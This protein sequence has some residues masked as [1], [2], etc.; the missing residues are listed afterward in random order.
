MI[1]T[2]FLLIALASMPLL[3]FAQATPAERSAANAAMTQTLNEH[4]DIERDISYAQNDN[5]RQRLDVY[6][7]KQR[8]AA[9][10]PVIVFFHGGGWLQGDKADCARMIS[11]VLRSGHFAAVAVGY[12][13]TNEATWP[14]QIH[15]S[16]AGVRWVRANAAK[17]GFDAN[18][19]GVWGASAGGHLALM[20]GVTGDVTTLE[21]SVGS[22]PKVSSRVT[23]VANFLGITDLRTLNGQTGSAA[24]GRA[25]ELLIGGPV[26]DNA[27]KAAA[28]SPIA[29]VNAKS[30][31]VLT[32]HGT[33]DSTVPFDQAV[34]FDAALRKAGGT[35][36]LVTVEGGGHGD[37][38]FA[39]NDRLDAFFEKYLRNQPVEIDTTAITNWRR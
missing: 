11:Q 4:F 29:Y 28:A 8:S 21:G 1:R 14:A 39:A 25:E 19:I 13:L 17:Y 24:G 23:A 9:P 7:P 10:L 16:K 2:K 34:K 12:R 22:Y 31:P 6:R 36:Y 30:A 27:D 18:R 26:R 5:P 3:A 38:G 15:D 33:A 37:F 35:S 20:L 32:V